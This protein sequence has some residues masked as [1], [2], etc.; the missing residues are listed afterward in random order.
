MPIGRRAFVTQTI[1]LAAFPAGAAKSPP[2][3]RIAAIRWRGPNGDLHGFM[4][5]PA[6][7][8]GPQPA[9]LITPGID[10]V[11]QFSLELTDALAQAGFVACI[12]KGLASLDDAIAT[13]RWLATNAYA[14]GKVAAIGLG[15]GGDLVDRIAG[16]PQP[17]LTAGITFGASETK[18][19]SVPLLRLAPI[20][21]LAGN[22]YEAAWRQAIAFL[23]EHLA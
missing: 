18:I 21:S 22:A 9:I 19:G 13:V 11:D 1:A 5:I 6:K 3:P 20:G 4:A 17:L 2:P 15:W 8:R 14:T 12:A 23:K 16:S 7:A 10:G